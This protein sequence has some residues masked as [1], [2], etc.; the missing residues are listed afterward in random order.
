MKTCI[1]IGAG[2]FSMNHIALEEN[3]F[4][5][6][7]DGGYSYCKLLGIEPDLI[8][9]DMDSLPK[10]RQ[11]EIDEISEKEPDRVVRLCP[12]KDDTDTL[13]A[14]RIGMGK[15][16]K[17]YRMYGALGGRM[18]HTIANIQCLCYLKNNGA[19]GTILEE[20]L[21]I[22]VIKEEKVWFDGR[23]K[24]YLSLFSLGERAEGVTITGMK[25]PLNKALVTND[26]PI[27]ISNEFIG[28][29][30]T[31]EVKKGML[32]AIHSQKS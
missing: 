4:C 5:I 15:G 12:E 20:G 11:K 14:L 32:L 21:S 23:G 3:D 10:E 24:G 19:E 31:V 9:G 6:A 28:E 22:T 17:N 27:G 16:Y 18:E 8:V 7:V 13:A 2:N 1:V 26:Y 30:S 25:Y 29:E